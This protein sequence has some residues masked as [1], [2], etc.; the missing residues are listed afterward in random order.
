MIY[1]NTVSDGGGTKF[2]YF[3]HTEN[4]VEGK[5]LIWPPDFTHTH[6]GVPS[7][8]EEKYIITGWY[9]YV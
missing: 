3:N 5:V 4:A 6:K 8:T 1:L 9:S 7:A 2:K